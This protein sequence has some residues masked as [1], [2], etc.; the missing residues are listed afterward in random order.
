MVLVENFHNARIL[1][2]GDVMLD[3]FVSGTIKRISPESPVPVLSLGDTRVYPGGAANVA[4]N[5]AALGGHC[6]LIG[7]IGDDKQG[8]D[9]A[10]ILNSLGTARP[11]F[12][13]AADRPTTEKTRYVS[14]GQHV[15]RVDEERNDPISPEIAAKLL[16]SVEQMIG[17]HD[18]LVLSDYAKGALTDD[19]LAKLIALARD[20]KLPIVVDPKSK[21]L[22]RYAG[23]T[24][25]TPNA[26]E[27][28]AATGIDPAQSD[29]AASEAADAALA[30]L[31]CDAILITRAEKGMTLGRRGRPAVHIASRAREVFD[32]VGAGDTVIAAL[33]LAIGAGGDIEEGA[34]LANVAAGI[35]V[36]RR[37]TATVSQSELLEAMVKADTTGDVSKISASGAIG[38][39]VKMWK[40][41]RLRVGFTNGCFDILHL[42]HI[43]LLR[44]ARRNCD[45]LVVG[46][47]SDESVRRLKGAD[48]PFNGEAD[49]AEVLAALEMVDSVVIFEDDTPMSLI[50]KIEPD[51]L[52]KG[53]DYALEQIV[54]ADFV[55]R[56]G[57]SVL[58]FELVPGK[59]SSGL[60]DKASGK[61]QL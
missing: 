49:R 27:T 12:A 42:G 59:S 29:S 52:V 41:D 35:V 60:I 23:A 21:S 5:I 54:G 26:K 33:A 39:T 44:Y 4:R 55:V 57:G 7:V 3:R 13:I 28:E 17:E 36:G 51:V 20:R 10:E 47:N 53:S 24:V 50:E 15:L 22:S 11:L 19:L 18:V 31:D 30:Q 6:T 34:R 58:R 38:E 46:L 14:Q 56:R 16:K 48:R 1:C 25:I 43:S 61:K 32:V 37:G 40:R 2:V 9:L 8:R 45:R